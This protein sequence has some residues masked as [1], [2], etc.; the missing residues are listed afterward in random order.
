MKTI[1]RTTTHSLGW[2]RP[3]AKRAPFA[4][5]CVGQ[6]FGPS[7]RK[8]PRL[9]RNTTADGRPRP[10]EGDA[11]ADS[12]WHRLP[13]EL[14][15][16]ILNGPTGLDA[17]HR[18]VARLVCRAWRDGVAA[19]SDA[20]RRRFIAS[21]PAKVDPHAWSAGRCVGA[22]VLALWLD[23]TLHASASAHALCMQSRLV[24]ASLTVPQIAAGVALSARRD[25]VHVAMA[26][27]GTAGPPAD[28]IVA[29]D[30][31]PASSA[32][33]H[34]TACPGGTRRRYFTVLSPCHAAAMM[35]CTAS[36]PMGVG[37]AHV[38]AAFSQAAS[39]PSVLAQ[40]EAAVAYDRA[41]SALSLTAIAIGRL[42]AQRMSPA[43]A[44]E[45]VLRRLWAAI[46]Q[47][48]AVR[49]A[50]WLG[51]TLGAWETPQRPQCRVRNATGDDGGGGSDGDTDESRLEAYYAY[52]ALGVWA[53]EMVAT[54]GREP[55]SDWS[56]TAARLG[57]TQLL[58]MARDRQ[59]PINDIRAF[60]AAL[61]AGHT[62]TCDLIARWYAHDNEGRFGPLS[63]DRA[64][65]VLVYASSSHLCSETALL[66]GLAWLASTVPPDDAPIE[67]LAQVLTPWPVLSEAVA[68]VDTWPADVVRS[69]HLCSG[70]AAYVDAARW[71]SADALVA[72]AAT[73]MGD[74]NGVA[75]PPAPTGHTGSALWHLWTAR[76]VE[77]VAYNRPNQDGGTAAVG[78]LGVLCALGVRAGFLNADE[79]PPV[80]LPLLAN[81]ALE[82]GRRNVTPAVSALWAG[83][84]RPAPLSLTLA[85]GV[86]ALAT[87]DPRYAVRTGALGLA[88]WLVRG[89]LC[90][91]VF[92]DA[93]A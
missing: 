87:E 85:L 43:S 46:A 64:V 66:R 69:G 84:V 34:D 31:S 68:L 49:T 17:A 76:L 89:G 65:N 36:G 59:W 41:A 52:E 27:M 22:S 29:P 48:N 11:P 42:Y 81:G 51:S 50:R 67:A 3:T 92:A 14:L 26:L 33:A 90:P 70:L 24:C 2:R 83:A 77:R 57:H 20:D 25:A 53:W 15:D 91:D 5:G 62:D 80:T 6:V 60:M 4:G 78:A 9:V 35:I 61:C 40:I 23:R 73:L 55:P 16:A 56:C 86:R 8:R 44:V 74:D 18:A 93:L 79:T 63:C 1:E 30:L 39:L 7:P 47:H 45:T 12:P 32:V 10:S 13:A 28:P 82:G 75:R 19:V 88:R 71:H 37:A 38:V 21:A 54:W 58:Q 72:L